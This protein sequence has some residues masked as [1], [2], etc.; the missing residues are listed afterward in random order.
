MRG[1]LSRAREAISESSF[2]RPWNIRGNV[3]KVGQKLRPF[4]RP[5]QRASVK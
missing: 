2:K 5:R 1:E 3:G 4:E